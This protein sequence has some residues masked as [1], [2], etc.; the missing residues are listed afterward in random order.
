MA[1][2]QFQGQQ[3]SDKNPVLG[4]G[5]GEVPLAKQMP[6]VNMRTMASDVSSIKEMGGGDPRPYAP[7]EMPASPVPAQKEVVVPPI[8]PPVVPPQPDA[9]SP[10]MPEGSMQE[11]PEKKKSN[12]GI[13]VGVA[14]FVT[15]IGLAAVVYFFVLPMFLSDGSEPVNEGTPAA[16]EQVIPPAEEPVIPPAEPPAATSTEGIPEAGVPK[17]PVVEV[18]ASLFAT[19]ADLSAE[20]TL[21]EVTA[22]A[23]KK[24]FEASLVEVPVLRE[25]VF[26]GSDGKVLAFE[27]IVPLFMS[28]TFS[29]TTNALFSPDATFFSY[30]DNKGV[31]PGFALK[32]ASD[33]DLTVA[34]AA[35]QTI[36]ANNEFAALF[37]TSPGT[38]T[39]WKD[40]KVNDTAARYI[41]FSAQGI[42]FN[43]AWFDRTLIV[44][45]SYAG[46]QAA[47]KKL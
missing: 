30:T 36:E 42:A 5:E 39:T 12:S 44:S 23:V 25:M 10:M 6:D 27:N 28:S 29:S 38:P 35:I 18:H 43:Y 9:A 47:A 40:G 33:A 7:K 46:A 37:L 21:G 11:T 4:T 14:V 3:W 16:E 13:F 15:L 45:T 22:D 19:P 26:K 31:W 24:A 41:P 1:D 2:F 20:A 8:I 32:L 17:M 34:K